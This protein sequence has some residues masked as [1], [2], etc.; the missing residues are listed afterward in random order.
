MR[1]VT[2]RPANARGGEVGVGGEVDGVEVGW[3]VLVG[4][5]GPPTR[6]VTIIPMSARV[7]TVASTF[8]EVI[9]NRGFMLDSE[10]LVPSTS[11]PGA[12]SKRFWIYTHI[13]GYVQRLQSPNRG[14]GKCREDKDK[15][16]HIG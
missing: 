4:G 6:L 14:Y 5:D 3:L 10:W 16:R 1:T 12:A 13:E 2:S 15:K 7:P 8:P 11:L 9:L